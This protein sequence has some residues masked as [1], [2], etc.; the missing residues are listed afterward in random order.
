MKVILH[1]RKIKKPIS[2][3]FYLALLG[4]SLAFNMHANEATMPAQTLTMTDVV[5]LT[6]A[7][8][9][10]LTALVP[11][12]RVWQ[13][14]IQQ[15]SIGQQPQIG[16]T[17]EDALGT[18]EHSSF[19][20]MQ[21]TLSFSWV[22]QRELIDSRINVI[23]TKANALELEQQIKVLDLSAYA[24][25]QVIEILIKQERLKLNQIAI[26]QA[27]EVVEAMDKRVAAGKSSS[28]EMLLAKTELI[29]TELAVE[30]LKHE[31]IA[32]H[33]KLASLWGK[34]TTSFKL[35]GNLLALPSIP[36]TEKQLE[37]LKQHPL[38][39][40]FASEQ[41]IAQSQIELAHIDAKPQ[42]QFTTGV[43]RY[44]T[45]DDFGLVASVSIPWGS[46]N[47]NA[48]TIS[49]LK[50]QQEVLAHQK[51]ALMQQLDA[52]LYV[53]LQEV[54]HSNHVIDTMQQEVIP[55]LE[56]TVKA[57]SQAFD[58]GQLSYSQWSD[59]RRELLSAQSQLLDGYE[60][61]HLQHIEIQ[62]LTGQ[63]LSQ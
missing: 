36:S 10:D 41:R 11:Q 39:Q 40:Q 19:Q 12:K 61:L 18:G 16:F 27:K 9:P 21:S 44:E 3:R 42:W 50:A 26:T 25:K 13:G 48:G 63:S 58:K 38:L 47:R 33:Y 34:P 29:R 57:A 28:I 60:S 43:R 30:D 14:N 17:V 8:H 35:T 53:L 22:V 2:Y 37:L 15:A 1:N 31:L 32:S 24:A 7:N 6:L 54:E 55:T 23:K 56:A 5:S 52:Q 45:S 49:S 20:S 62:R 4:I 46:E 59:V 51:R